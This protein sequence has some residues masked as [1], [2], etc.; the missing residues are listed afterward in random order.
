MPHPDQSDH[1]KAGSSAIKHRQ[2][3]PMTP[4]PANKCI[5]AGTT[6]KPH[7]HTHTHHIDI[8]AIGLVFA[9]PS[10]GRAGSEE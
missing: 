7:T 4:T 1:I 10:D 2:T 9:G 5:H 3:F 6:A 8:F